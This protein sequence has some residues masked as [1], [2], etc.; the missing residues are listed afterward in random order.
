VQGALGKAQRER[1]ERCELKGDDVINYLRVAL[2]FNPLQFF[3]P[4]DEG[5]FVKD[6]KDIPEEVGRLVERMEVK[7]IVAPDGSIIRGYK[8]WFLSKAIVLPLAMKH[9]NLMGTEKVEVTPGDNWDKILQ[10]MGTVLDD[11]IENEI[12]AIDVK[13]KPPKKRKA[14]Q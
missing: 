7:E 8:L 10:A 11:D 6:W 13:S 3:T 1:E 9:L 12:D 4:C 5:F 2:F 14:I